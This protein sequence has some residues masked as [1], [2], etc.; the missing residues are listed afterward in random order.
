VRGSIEIFFQTVV[1][2]RIDIPS[3]YLILV[4]ATRLNGNNQSSTLTR[5]M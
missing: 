2:A 5:I 1:G 3:D 4:T